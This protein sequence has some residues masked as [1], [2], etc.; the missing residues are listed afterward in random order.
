MSAINAITASSEA[1]GFPPANL[2]QYDPDL[3]WKAGS[4]LTSI[5]LVIDLAVAS[6]IDHVWLNNANFLSATVQANST[7]AWSAPAFS[8]AVVLAADDI[9]VVKGFFNLTSTKYRYVRIVIPTQS[10]TDGGTVPSL[11]NIIVGTSDYLL[12]S[13]WEPTIN[14]ELDSFTSDGGSYNEEA[15]GKARH[16][17]AAGMLGETKAG[18]DAAPL[19]NWSTAVIF[20]DLGSVADSY[21]VYSPKGKQVRVRSQIDCDLSFT[22]RELV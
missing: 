6:S 11:G 14:Q 8:I 13:T 9:G 3:I 16:I 2:L 20:T 22:L 18:I 12:V 4:F 19:S 1:V 21:L 15:R 7:N 17:F 10:L 5:T